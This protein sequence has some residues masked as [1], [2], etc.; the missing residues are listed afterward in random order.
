M[1]SAIALLTC[2][3]CHFH[4]HVLFLEFTHGLGH[5]H[6]VHLLVHLTHCFGSL[7]HGLGQFHIGPHGLGTVSSGLDLA[8]GCV[9]TLFLFPEVYQVFLEHTNSII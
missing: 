6:G 5:F 7:C 4:P 8:S 1:D 2:F 3:L 9:G